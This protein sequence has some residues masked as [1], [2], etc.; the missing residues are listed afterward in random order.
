MYMSYHG[1]Q[2]GSYFLLFRFCKDY[3][4]SRL[5]QHHALWHEDKFKVLAVYNT[6]TNC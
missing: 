1:L 5:N 6:E 4:I 3:A 2:G